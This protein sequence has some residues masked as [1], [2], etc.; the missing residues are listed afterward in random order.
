MYAAVLT[1]HSWLRWA[2]L[3]LGL[4]ATLNAFRHHSDTAE[5]LPGARWDTLFMMALDLQVLFGLVLYLGLSPFTA[6]ALA[7]F[8]A[9]M[10]NS[11]LRF[12]AVEHISTMFVAVIAVRVGRVLAITSK[13]PAAKQRRR[14]VC[15]A[16]ATLAM[17]A[18]IPWP[19]AQNGRPLFRF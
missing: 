4:G 8:G 18:A 5:R 13:T 1:I 14:L 12:W 19:G 15:F 11:E 9:A 2:A 17:I 10:R 3:L 7:D 6:E 16:I